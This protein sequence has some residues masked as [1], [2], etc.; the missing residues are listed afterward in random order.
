MTDQMTL[1]AGDGTTFTVTADDFDAATI[2]AQM[3]QPLALWEAIVDA[4]N[5]KKGAK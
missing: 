2:W 3:V 1:L 5:M 4:W